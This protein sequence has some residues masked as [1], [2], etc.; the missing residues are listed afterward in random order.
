[1]LYRTLAAAPPGIQHRRASP[2]GRAPAFFAPPPP[3]PHPSNG[4]PGRPF[5]SGRTPRGP[6]SLDTR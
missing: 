5:A 2:P 3:G 1:M 6:C 4:L